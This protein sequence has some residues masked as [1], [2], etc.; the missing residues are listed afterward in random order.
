MA[1]FYHCF[2]DWLGRRE[3]FALVIQKEN[4]DAAEVEKKKSAKTKEMNKRNIAWTKAHKPQT[5]QYCAGIAV[6]PDS[7]KLRLLWGLMINQITQ[8]M[9]GCPGKVF[10]SLDK[11]NDWAANQLGHAN[12]D[13]V[14]SHERLKVS[15]GQR[16]R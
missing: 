11:A 12:S 3:R 4:A 10:I 5:A 9:Y 2:E 15:Q 14:G 7:T 8:K 13:L 6:V 1:R 16:E